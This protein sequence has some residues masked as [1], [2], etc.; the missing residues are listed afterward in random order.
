MKAVVASCLVL[1]LA[2]GWSCSGKRTRP[3]LPAPEYER[4]EVAPYDAGRPADP[5]DDDAGEWLD[6]EDDEP[7]PPA[8][9]PD[10]GSQDA[11]GVEAGDSAAP[12]AAVDAGGGS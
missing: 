5:L 12:A 10:A 3:A 7:G 9:S 11:A 1:S 6:F 2:A 4:H 8:A